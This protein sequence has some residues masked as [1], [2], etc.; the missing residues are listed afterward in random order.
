MVA[1][2]VKVDRILLWIKT[3]HVWY[4]DHLG[5]SAE[6]DIR[7]FDDPADWNKNAGGNKAIC[8]EILAKHPHDTDTP[9]LYKVTFFIST[10]VIQIQ[11]NAKDKFVKRDFPILI[12]LIKK[13]KEFNGEQVIQ[14]NTPTSSPVKEANEEDTLGKLDDDQTCEKQLFENKGDVNNNNESKSSNQSNEWS[15]TQFRPEKM[16]ERMENFFVLALDKICT[17]QSELFSAKMKTM[18]D[19]Y[20]NHMKEND[21]KLAKVLESVTKIQSAK[22]D[23]TNACDQKI[24]NK[25][26]TLEHENSDLKMSLQQV[27]HTTELDKFQ[28]QSK[29][30]QQTSQSELQKVNHNKS[31]KQLEFEINKL[32]TTIHEKDDKLK[33]LVSSCNE[34]KSKLEEKDDELYSLKQHACRDDGAA[35]FQDVPSRNRRS[36]QNNTDKPHVILI[37]TSNTERIDVSKLSSKF[38]ME[39]RIAYT[40]PDTELSLREIEHAPDIIVFHS[41]TNELREKSAESCVNKMKEI[42]SLAGELFIL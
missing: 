27:K 30:D 22:S 25:L 29:L 28:L 31:Q 42:V 14:H 11:G 37:G 21:N 18:E 13:I 12:A 33:T 39:K 9:L 5:N 41:L 17:K 26:N 6:H 10:G 36:A 34:L 19:S 23:S 16:L 40:L 3:L 32:E 1:F 7:W 35:Q 15:V 4:Y 20:I 2:R 38:T 8:I 24:F